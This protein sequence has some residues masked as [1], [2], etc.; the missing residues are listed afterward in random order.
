M[1][2]QF[3]KLA[4]LAGA[5]SAQVA[6]MVVYWLRNTCQ[7]RLKANSLVASFQINCGDGA[8]CDTSS[9]K[10]D[11]IIQLN[12]LRRNAWQV[13]GCFILLVRIRHDLL[14]GDA[15]QQMNERYIHLLKIRCAL[16][17]KRR[18]IEQA[19]PSCAASASIKGSKSS[20]AMLPNMIC[21][22]CVVTL[23]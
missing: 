13:G 7:H 18:L 8:K 11:L 14:H 9:I 12:I 5:F 4:A 3:C 20:C 17:Q 1:S 6:T 10:N 21:T 22:S 16:S 23:P 19:L 2:R 15:V